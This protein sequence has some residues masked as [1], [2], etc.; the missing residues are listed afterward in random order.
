M[1]QAVSHWPVNA[2][3]RVQSLDN[4]CRF[5][6]EQNGTG[7]GFCGV[8]PGSNIPPVLHTHSF[9]WHRPYKI[10]AINSVV[11]QHAEF[12]FVNLVTYCQTLVSNTWTHS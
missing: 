3:T 7:T 8:S 2:M 4:G 10:L 12:N 5:C 11:K 6:G 9:V 1:I